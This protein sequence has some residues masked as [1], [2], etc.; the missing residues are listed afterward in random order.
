MA[1]VNIETL[2][3]AAPAFANAEP[4]DHVIVDNFFDEEHARL[5]ESEF[6]AF[7]EAGVWHEYR[8]PIEAKRVCNNWNV[9]PKATYSTFAYLNS[10]EFCGEL[11]SALGLEKLHSDPGLNGGGWHI[12]GRGG[13]L[14]T[15]LDYS[16]HP[17]LGMQ[18]KLNI[19]VYLNSRWQNEWG[20]QLGLWRGKEGRHGPGELVKSVDPAFN[21]AVIFD[22]TQNSWHGLPAPLTCPEGEARQSLAVYYLCPAPADVDRR[23]KAYFAPTAEQECD[24][25]VLE[26]IRMRADEKTASKVYS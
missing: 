19:I 15:H 2:Q 12:H 11:A 14:N 16:V 22:T 7:D 24:E 8:N 18:R 9:F 3:A 17:K 21:R 23:G 25:S 13:K 6:P 26:L 20:G 4:F 1:I 10:P 5:L